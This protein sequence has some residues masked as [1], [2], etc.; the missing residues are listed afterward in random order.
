M[1]IRKILSLSADGSKVVFQS[2]ASNLR[3]VTPIIHGIFLLKDLQTGTITRVNTS[4]SGEQ[5]NGWSLIFIIIRWWQ[6]IVYE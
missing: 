6:S 4:S 5:A 2:L 1:I 3:Q